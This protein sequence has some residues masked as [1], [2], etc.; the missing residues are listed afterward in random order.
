MLMLTFS[1]NASSRSRSC[2]SS[3]MRMVVDFNANLL[4]GDIMAVYYHTVNP[5]YVEVS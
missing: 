4:S 1:R 2:N 5:L 3:G